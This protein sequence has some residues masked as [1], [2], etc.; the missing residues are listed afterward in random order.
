MTSAGPATFSGTDWNSA[1]QDLVN[2]QASTSWK[3]TG[4]LRSVAARMENRGQKPV[5]S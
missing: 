2:L 1:E 5:P 3:V 4:P